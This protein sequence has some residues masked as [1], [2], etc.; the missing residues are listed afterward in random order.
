MLEQDNLFEEIFKL[1]FQAFT[2]ETL[3]E[4]VFSSPEFFEISLKDRNGHCCCFFLFMMMMMMM[5][6]TYLKPHIQVTVPSVMM[7]NGQTRKRT[8][9]KEVIKIL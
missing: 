9:N 6:I 1:F 8:H 2:L 4:K 7:S 3:I 5:M